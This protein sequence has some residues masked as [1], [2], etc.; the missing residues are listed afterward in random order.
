V[1]TARVMPH[2]RAAG[3]CLRSRTP[4]PRHSAMQR[5]TA[6]SDPDLRNDRPIERLTANECMARALA[7]SFS[8]YVVLFF[9]ACPGRSER[10]MCGVKERVSVSFLCLTA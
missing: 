8:A 7:P 5:A 1:R 10:V 2:T 9:D 3:L 4:L 6:N